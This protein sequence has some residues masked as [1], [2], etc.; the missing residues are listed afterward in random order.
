L[1][2]I[3]RKH[4]LFLRRIGFLRGELRVFLSSNSPGSPTYVIQLEEVA[5][6]FDNL[7]RGAEVRISDWPEHGSF[8]WW[9]PADDPHHSVKVSGVGE[10]AGFFLGLA[11]RVQ[12]RIADDD[13]AN[14]WPG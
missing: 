7:Q 12:Y 11:R 4:P 8:G 13:E 10:G 6:F 5:S 3:A 9:L 2:A 14:N 1:E